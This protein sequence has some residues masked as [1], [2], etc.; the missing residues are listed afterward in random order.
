MDASQPQLTLEPEILPK[1]PH[2]LIISY[3]TR[4]FNAAK[5]LN[6]SVLMRNDIEPVLYRAEIY[7]CPYTHICR[8]AVLESEGKLAVFAPTD[9]YAKITVSPV[10]RDSSA[11]PDLVLTDFTAIPLTEW[12]TNYI[13]ARTSCVLVDGVCQVF[14]FSPI[15]DSS[16]LEAESDLQVSSAAKII[17]KKI[18]NGF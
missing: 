9:G 8:A 6:V 14:E 5:Q 12:N 2:H 17:L 15:P 4:D 3:F 16:V 11:N 7:N 18:G 13:R 1:E 10:G